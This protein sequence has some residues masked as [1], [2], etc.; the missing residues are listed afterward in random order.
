MLAALGACSAP[1]GAPTQLP[2]TATIPSTNGRPNIILI[3]TDDMDETSLAYMPKVQA[4]IADQGMRLTNYIV[5][6]SLCCPS[7]ATTLCGQY[8]HNT[9][10]LTNKPPNGG[11]EKF[12]QDGLEDKTIAVTLQA[13]GYRTILLGKYLNGYPGGVDMTHIPAG[14]TEWYAPVEG[15]PYSEFNYTL[16]Q[17]GELIE[18]GSQPQDYASD[19][20]AGLAADFIQRNA[21]MG[22]PFF[23]YLA[24]YAPHSPA[25]SAPRHAGLFTDLTAPQPASFNETDVSDKP[26][27]IRNLPLLTEKDIANINADYRKRL[28]SLQA[29]DDLVEKLVQTL[30][31]TGQLENT[32]IFFTSDNGFH[33]GQH[34]LRSGKQA[35]Y[36]D[37][38]RLPFLARGPGV[39]SGQARAEL[40]GNVDLAAT[41]ADLA[42][43]HIP[44]SY[45]GRSLLPLLRGESAPEDWRQA[46]L[47]ENWA[48]QSQATSFLGW[49]ASLTGQTNL[50]GLLEP[51]DRDELSGMFGLAYRK[52]GIPEFKGLR[53]VN[54]LYVEY[55]TGERELYDLRADPYQL[56]NL[57]ASSDPLLMQQFSDWLTRLSAC[58]GE[59]CRV[60]ESKLPAALGGS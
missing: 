26:A 44:D 16:N 10:I 33:L 24:T 42:G 34:R 47:I 23:I 28:Q 1:L 51:P 15:K 43:I 8:S 19:V 40:A 2:S 52:A 57:A 12:Y 41:F 13:A 30:Q 53:T 49:N 7:R 31:S 14:W 27:Y 5:N 6:V 59:S 60:N 58:A 46:F 22:Q 56:D 9:H 50:A 25:T 18:Y 11:Y 45:D 4:L 32:Y 48:Q 54:Y 17:N 36:E 20:F 21:A 37:D 29:V 55:A 38:I 3:L 39:P 35:P